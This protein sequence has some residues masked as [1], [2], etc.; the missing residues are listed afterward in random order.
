MDPFLLL[1]FLKVES[2]ESYADAM[3]LGGITIDVEV[4]DKKI[5]YIDIL[6]AN[7]SAES[8]IMVLQQ[9]KKTILEKAKP[10]VGSINGSLVMQSGLLDEVGNG[11]MWLCICYFIHGNN[12]ELYICLL[13]SKSRW[14]TCP[15]TRQVSQVLPW[16]SK[17]SPNNGL[18]S[19][20][21]M[22]DCF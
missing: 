17:R 10:L 8:W 5:P 6:I 7:L 12:C 20:C 1:S 9:R 14:S 22:I 19:T 15:G 16:A 11:V 18:F 13:G 21:L 4:I 3:R 2:A